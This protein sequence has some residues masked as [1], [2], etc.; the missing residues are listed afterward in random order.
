MIVAIYARKSTEQERDESVEPQEQSCRELATAKGWH[1]DD[2]Y[3]F[4]A[5]EQRTAGERP[6]STKRRESSTNPRGS[7]VDALGPRQGQ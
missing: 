4:A 6:N 3:V 7:V 5:F 1:V 2:R